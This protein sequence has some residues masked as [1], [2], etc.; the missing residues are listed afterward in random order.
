MDVRLIR[1]ETGE[2]LQEYDNVA[3]G[4]FSASLLGT[5]AQGNATYQLQVRMPSAASSGG[6]FCLNR[7]VTAQV[8]K[9]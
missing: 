3:D 2:V 9:R 4:V 5:P 7:S 6:A 1:V 8:L